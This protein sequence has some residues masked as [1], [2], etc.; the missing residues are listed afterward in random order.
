MT[1]EGPYP[2][3]YPSGPEGYPQDAYPPYDDAVGNGPP[4]APPPGSAGNPGGAF[5]QGSA[6]ARAAVRMPPGLRVEGDGQAGLAGPVSGQPQ[7]A[8][9]RGQVYGRPSAPATYGSPVQPAGSYGPAQPGD[10]GDPSYR[11]GGAGRGP[12]EADERGAGRGYDGAPKLGEYDAPRAYGE[13]G[14]HPDPGYGTS[15]GQRAPAGYSTPSEPVPPTARPAAPMMPPD[16]MSPAGA[17]APRVYGQPVSGAYDRDA[18]GEPERPAPHF[19]QQSEQGRVPQQRSAGPQRAGEDA[20]G[21]QP[22]VPRQ[23]GVYGRPVE[24]PPAG[25]QPLYGAGSAAPGQLAPPQYPAQPR[26]DSAP[27][28]HEQLAAGSCPQHP[29][30]P[31]QTARGN[32]LDPAGQAQH[33]DGLSGRSGLP[34]KAIGYA[35]I[36]LLVIALGAGALYYTSRPNAPT[37]KVNECVHESSGGAVAV[38]CSSPGAFRIVSRVS[39]AAKCPDANQPHVKIDK[40]D[41]ATSI[42][43]LKP[44]S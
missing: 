2:H 37:F 36:A 22:S 39:D 28:W 7:S 29:V 23:S 3:G 25:P 17:P 20:A 14:G 44:A 10:A 18:Y 16:A 41:P 6:Q 38:A 24:A 35:A 32:P 5:P 33:P 27:A 19:D 21:R 40:A 13:A 34:W 30:A 12:G 9:G 15:P 26:V 43:C 31:A 11:E 42:A 8:S 1:S 4:D